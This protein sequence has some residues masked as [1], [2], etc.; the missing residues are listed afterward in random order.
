MKKALYFTIALVLTGALMVNCSSG[1]DGGS[2]PSTPPETHDT[3]TEV[4]ETDATETETEVEVDE[5]GRFV[6]IRPRTGLNVSYVDGDFDSF[7]VA[8]I[9]V[10]DFGTN[11]TRVVSENRYYLGNSRVGC[12][13]FYYAN[14]S[15]SLEQIADENDM[16]IHEVL[17][18]I[19]AGNAGRLFGGSYNPDG[20]WYFQAG[21]MAEE[22]RCSRSIAESQLNN[23]AR[24]GNARMTHIEATFSA[25]RELNRREL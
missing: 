3:E 24:V 15:Q 23:A 4:T 19:G 11:I 5:N 2:S 12:D 20:L 21:F 10:Y 16:S 7:E 13:V 25:V 6:N 17:V 8:Q 14:D 18:E 22:G 9:I 1:G